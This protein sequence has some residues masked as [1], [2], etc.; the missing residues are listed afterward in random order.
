MTL[1]VY[2]HFYSIIEFF[3]HS[4]SSE[5]LIIITHTPLHTSQDEIYYEIDWYDIGK[6]LRFGIPPH[7]TCYKWWA[8]WFRAQQRHVSHLM[9]IILYSIGKF[10]CIRVSP[11]GWLLT[12]PE[13]LV[14]AKALP[15]IFHLIKI[16]MLYSIFYLIFILICNW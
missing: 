10:P 1:F 13:Y 3:Q 12:L 7:A 9:T 6:S 14:P 16:N 15:F 11:Q 8:L 5:T 4:Y 2:Q